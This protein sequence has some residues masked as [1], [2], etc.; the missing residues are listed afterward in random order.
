MGD[1]KDFALYPKGSEVL[2][3]MG[4]GSEELFSSEVKGE[5][6]GDARHKH[7]PLGRAAGWVEA[8]FA[9]RGSLGRGL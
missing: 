3:R 5:G 6:E 2:P 8:E 4:M 1:L 9:E 7:R